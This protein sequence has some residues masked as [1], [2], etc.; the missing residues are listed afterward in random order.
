MHGILQR[1]RA[2]KALMIKYGYELYLD[3]LRKK[4]MRGLEGQKLRGFSTGEKVYGYY[5][6]PVG[7]LKLNKRGEAKY[8][9]PS[10]L[11]S[12]LGG[13]GDE[14]LA[15]SDKQRVFGG[16]SCNQFEPLVK[17]P[18]TSR[19]FLLASPIYI[20]N[21]PRKQPNCVYWG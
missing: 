10:P 17:Y 21:C 16:R 1:I 4:T 13:E 7:E 3:D 12:P 9:S 11:P 18:P 15:T 14:Q 20:K 8:A 2:R 6:R 5:T 19:S